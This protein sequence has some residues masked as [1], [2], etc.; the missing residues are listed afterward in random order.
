[1][2]WFGSNT[3]SIDSQIEKATDESIPFGETDL[4]TSLEITDLIRSKQVLPKDAMR[5]LKK[6]LTSSK[7]PNTQL[8]TLHLIDTCVKNGG[9]HFIVE[10]STREFID[11]INL[12]IRDDETNENVRDL[13]LD[14]IQNWSLAF[15][16]NFQFK[17]LGQIYENLQKS[18]YSFPTVGSEISTKLFDSNAPPE[19]EDSDAC[20]ICSTLF[21][22]L[23]RKHHC[24]NCGGVFCTTHSSKFLSLSHLGIIEPVRVCDTCFDELDSKKSKGKKTRRSKHQKDVSRAR[25]QYDSDDDEDL[26]KALE[27]SLRESQGF[28]QVPI[29]VIP[30]KQDQKSSSQQQKQ[31]SNEDEEDED[32]KAAIAASLKDLED[33]KQALEQQQQQQQQQPPQDN[34]P[35]A[36]LLPQSSGYQQQQQH[37][38]QQVQQPPQD[39]PNYLTSQDESNI[40][41]F[42][43]KVS[44]YE[45][46]PYAQNDLNELH[47]SY[48]QVIPTIPKISYEL[49]NSINKYDEFI[50]LNSKIDTVMRL[51]NKMLDDKI[52]KENNLTRAP[53]PVPSDPY[54]YQQQYQHYPSQQYQQQYQSQQYNQ[55]QGYTPLNQQYSGQTPQFVQSPSLE[56][57]QVELQKQ[58]YQSPVQQYLQ[59]HLQQVQSSPQLQQQAPQVPQQ[60]PQQA[61]QPRY[62]ESVPSYNEALE[63]EPQEYQP[64]QE[65]EEEEEE[66]SAPPSQ[67][68]YE[69]KV[70][71]P[72]PQ[73]LP[74]EPSIPVSQPQQVQQIP[75][76]QVP[77][78][79]PNGYKYQQKVTDFSFPTVPLNKPP[80]EETIHVKEDKK[81]IVE[82]TLIEL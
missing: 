43:N 16:D 23:N 25:A 39:L 60:A 38:Q 22:M 34:S 57:Q 74:S 50:D 63:Q 67:I 73:H 10:I 45:S 32:M 78:Q 41:Q 29:P 79:V 33:K 81:P 8:S 35:Y 4:S 52:E 82:E 1:M 30:S 72:I 3:V 47:N 66:F 6:R 76:Q 9:Y 44:Y 68:P 13:A 62:E 2:S 77:S 40:I 71:E 27:L 80:Q 20:M 51:Y 31:T 55:Q 59:P 19:W 26:K 64:P 70:E 54:G 58:S 18:G 5:S 49:N 46:T 56:R 11:S 28:T 69:N 12:I 75:S 53:V 15:K 37:V 48:R 21:S 61:P 14:L 7:N 65:E 17:Y 42:N 24:R 36:N